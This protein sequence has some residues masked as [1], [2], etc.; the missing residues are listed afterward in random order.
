M[1]AF[2]PQL[3]GATEKT[4]NALLQHV[5][6]DAALP[7]PHWVTLRLAAQNTTT[8]PLAPLVAARAHFTDAEAIVAELTHRG[9]IRGDEPT[10]AGRALLNELQSRIADLTAPIWDGLDPDDVAATTRVLSAVASRAD[11][12]LESLA[13][14]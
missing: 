9:L 6:R 1:P 3:I 7:E 5:L 11:A 14:R 2:G 10:P 4:L 12:V 8:L 13:S